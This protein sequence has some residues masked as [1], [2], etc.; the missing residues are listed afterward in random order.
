MKKI[1]LLPILILAISVLA[2]TSCGKDN[3]PVVE[4]KITLDKDAHSLSVGDV[5]RLKATL[6]PASSKEQIEWSSDKKDVATVSQSGEVKAVAEGEA[7]IT[8]ALKNGNK[9]TCKITVR[10]AEEPE[11]TA[12]ISLDKESYTLKVGEKVTLVATVTQENVKVTWS[13]DKEEIA[14]VSEKGEIEAL[15]EGKATITAALEG[16]G[17]AACAITVT[18]K[19]AEKPKPEKGEKAT[20]KFKKDSYTIKVGESLDLK[21]EVMVTKGTDPDEDVSL[22]WTSDDEEIASVKDGVIKGAKAGNTE[23]AVVLKNNNEAACKIIVT[24]DSGSDDK[25]DDKPEVEKVEITPTSLSLQVGNSQKLEIKGREKNQVVL[26]S[27]DESIATVTQEG[28]VTGIKQ[29]VTKIRVT[30]NGVPQ[31]HYISVTIT[32]KAE[33]GRY[34]YTIHHVK[35]DQYTDDIKS[36]VE[37]KNKVINDTCYTS[38]SSRDNRCFIYL[39]ITDTQTGTK[40]ENVSGR[41]EIVESTVGAASTAMAGEVM[42]YKPCEFKLRIKLDEYGIDD[43]IQVKITQKEGYAPKG[44]KKK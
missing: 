29:G 10:K 38:G 11:K 18:K 44:E 22:S 35:K 41:W 24:S 17:K 43:T 39:N 32:P 19:D 13:S 5:L 36:N 16:G 42:W 15:A 21:N 30:I 14:T 25:P 26:K 12:K 7:T 23:I 27:E 31:H 1:S 8:A 34:T 4:T 33:A 2:L 20:V 3:K 37:V 6:N 9:S 40:K 28:L